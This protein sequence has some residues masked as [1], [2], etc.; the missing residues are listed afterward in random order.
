M[1]FL[2]ILLP[3]ILPMIQNCLEKRSSRRVEASLNEPGWIVSLLLRRAIKREWGLTGEALWERHAVCWKALTTASP[4]MVTVVVEAA[5]RK[6][7][8]VAVPTLA[9]DSAE[10]EALAEFASIV[11]EAAVEAFDAPVATS[12]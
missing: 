8:R 4:A 9:T 7:P 1:E 5:Q 12:A 6:G 3:M 2:L 10:L 11:D